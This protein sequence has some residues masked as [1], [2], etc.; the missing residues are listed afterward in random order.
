MNKTELLKNLI[1]EGESLSS[2]ISYVPA[3]PNVFRTFSVY[4]T[5]QVDKY[6][7]WQSS[8]QRF[9]KSYYPSDLTDFKEAAKKLSP[10]NHR[11]ILG[12]LTAIELLPEE[13]SSSESEYKSGTNITIHNSQNNTQ[14]LVLNLFMD[15]IKDEITGKELKQL[16]EI[17]AEYEIEPEKNKS[18]L[19]EKIKS[20]GTDVLTNIVANIITN[21]AFYGGLM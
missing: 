3:P 18:K 6:Q 9:I 5:S 7:S 2:T 10:E 19:T 8:T 11:K 16:K 13:P 14:N 1:I 12:L 20:F 4:K 15:A 21:P 17:L